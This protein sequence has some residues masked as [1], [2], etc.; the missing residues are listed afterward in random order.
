MSK[1]NKVIVD[2]VLA[3]LPTTFSS[4]A[5][6]CRKATLLLQSLAKGFERGEEETGCKTKRKMNM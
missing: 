5:Q 3:K 4:N 1:R 2:S 6:E